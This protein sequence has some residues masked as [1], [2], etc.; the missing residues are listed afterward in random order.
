METEN[1]LQKASRGSLIT[2]QISSMTLET[3]L[4]KELDEAARLY[5]AEILKGDLRL[6]LK[7][8]DGEKP[9]IVQQGFTEY[10]M[11]GKFMPKPA[12]IQEQ[13]RLIRQRINAS[14]DEREKEERE[15]VRKFMAEHEG[16]TPME[17]FREENRDLIRKL[18]MNLVGGSADSPRNR[19]ALEQA[20]VLGATGCESGSR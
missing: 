19:K 10:Y 3:C 8:F 11:V 6:W 17:V 4:A 16:K 5:K 18:D 12:D 15:A 13:V 14:E 9:Q 1:K 20:R 7:V 2:A